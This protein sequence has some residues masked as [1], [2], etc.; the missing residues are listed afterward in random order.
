MIAS[1]ERRIHERQAIRP[2]PAEFE[3]APQQ[4]SCQAEREPVEGC[5][6]QC[7]EP[8]EQQQRTQYLPN[9][10]RRQPYRRTETR[11]DHDRNKKREK[12]ALPSVSRR[13]ANRRTAPKPALMTAIMPATITAPKKATTIVTAGRERRTDR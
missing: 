9:R 13:S 1:G 3:P 10:Q 12:G 7:E 2:P 4:C 8:Q 11:E 6:E 5:V